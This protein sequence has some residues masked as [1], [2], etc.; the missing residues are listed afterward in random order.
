MRN[1]KYTDGFSFPIN[2]V[3]FSMVDNCFRNKLDSQVESLLP[4]NEFKAG[5]IHDGKVFKFWKDELKAA[6][7]VLDTL[8]E[9]YKIP[10]LSRPGVYTER[11][12][13]SA[14]EQPDIVRIQMKEM[15]QKK[16]V[17]VVRDQPTCINPLGLV[18]KV[19]DDGSFKH[20][21]VWDGSRHVNNHLMPQHVRLSHLDKALELTL[22]GDFQS[23][24]DL[25]SA[26]YH[27]KIHPSQ[28]TF[29][30]SA[31]EEEDGSVVYVEYQVLPFGLASAVHAITKIM[32][33]IVSYITALN[34]RFSIYIDDGRITANSEEEIEKARVAVYNAVTKAGWAIAVEKSDAFKDWSKRKR[35][36]G[37]DIDSEQMKVYAPLKKIEKI[38]EEFGNVAQLRFI[39]VKRLA[40][41]LG[42]IL[43]LEPSHGMLVRV[44]TR[45]AY[46]VLSNHTDNY[47][48]KG[49]V[50]LTDS[51]RIELEFCLRHLRSANGSLI[52]TS[53][54]E[55]RLETLID[56]P[57]TTRDRI[58]NH[59]KGEMFL[60]SDASQVKAFAYNLSSG[61]NHS[62][63]VDVLFTWQQQNMSSTARELLALLFTLQ[64]W[65]ASASLSGVNV[66]WATD[67]QSATFCIERGSRKQQ[68]QEIIFEITTICK[69]LDVHITPI[70]LLREDPRIML[71]DEGSKTPNSDNWSVDA[72][73][74]Q[75]LHEEVGFQADLFASQENAR[76]PAFCSLSFQIYFLRFVLSASHLRS[77]IL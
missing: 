46:D 73:S 8:I 48:W 68:I 9:G 75:Q 21:L 19:Q 65:K 31:Y 54:T 52:K 49:Y 61:N 45:A 16:V 66:Y 1:Q 71:A 35:Y 55:V 67:S 13:L 62:T 72:V 33:P 63:E 3:V 74:F 44:A 76:V 18:S 53:L 22:K 10:F 42:K 56:N 37:F 43:S 5:S 70:H 24:F 34:I 77:M 17:K 2:C 32:K 36:L 59:P 14:R 60:V 28:T 30:G 6:N 50:L 7:W 64:S 57:V 40:S 51:A 4:F 11:N 47:G 58:P 26:Y 12:N 15:I 20:R 23:T 39:P 41:L 27:I 69:D 38:E 25:S 29:L